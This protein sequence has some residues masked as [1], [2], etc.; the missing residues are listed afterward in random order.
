MKKYIVC[1]TR[2][3]QEFEIEATSKAEAIA[4][5]KTKCNFSVWESEANEI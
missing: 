1:L 5:A 4:K 3:P 2:Y